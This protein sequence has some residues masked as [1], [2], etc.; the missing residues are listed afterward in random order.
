MLTQNILKHFKISKIRNHRD[1]DVRRSRLNPPKNKGPSNRFRSLYRFLIAFLGISFLA[2]EASTFMILG[3]GGYEAN[4]NVSRLLEIHPILYPLFDI[5]ALLGIII[6]F[7]KVE[8]IGVSS[9]F[10]ILFPSIAR[11]L[12]ALHNMHVL[13]LAGG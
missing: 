3:A 10:I 11:S 6:L 12:F 7:K 4:P 1:I 13:L 2:D 8:K 5:L 9:L